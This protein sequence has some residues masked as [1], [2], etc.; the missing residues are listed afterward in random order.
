MSRHVTYH[1]HIFPYSNQNQ[2]FQWQYHSNQP[3]A[4]TIEPEPVNNLNTNQHESTI[5]K[6][7]NPE[8]FEP[9][10][11][12]N[13][14]LDNHNQPPAQNLPEPDLLPLR[15][16]TRTIQKPTHLSDYV[17]NLSKESDDSSSSGILYP[18][19][20]FHSLNNLSPSHQKFA[21]AVTNA[22]EPTS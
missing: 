13:N 9:E 10:I 6:A 4:S 8:D 17:C 20:H 12:S 19:T 3:I 2:P 15:K 11:S 16:S 1:E 14:E 22:F 7:T 21:L 5:N 18:I